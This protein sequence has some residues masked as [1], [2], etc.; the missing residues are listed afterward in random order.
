MSCKLC[1]RKNVLRFHSMI[2]TFSCITQLTAVTGTLAKLHIIHYVDHPLHCRFH[3]MKFIGFRS[4]SS[5]SP[6]LL[7]IILSIMTNRVQIIFFLILLKAQLATE[8]CSEYFAS[9]QI[10]RPQ[11]FDDAARFLTCPLT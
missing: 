4:L 6:N 2:S 10:K 5:A 9:L 11:S 7:S 1:I 8:Y 3:S